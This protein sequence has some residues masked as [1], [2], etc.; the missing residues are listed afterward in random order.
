MIQNKMPQLGTGVQDEGGKSCQEIEKEGL[1]KEQG[2]WE[3][4]PSARTNRILE[5]E[6]VKIRKFLIMRVGPSSRYC[7]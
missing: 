7:P 1:R 3:F 6:E 2:F 5:D 4:R